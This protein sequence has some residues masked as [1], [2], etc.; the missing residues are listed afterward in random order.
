[1][2]R[3]K[4]RFNQYKSSIKLNGEGKHGFKQ[5]QSIKHFFLCRHNRT[6]EDIKVWVIDHCDLND[7]EAR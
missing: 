6:H 3:F 4:L 1:M 2:A 5:E 7:R